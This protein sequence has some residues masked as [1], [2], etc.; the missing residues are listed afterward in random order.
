MNYANLSATPSRG[1]PRVRTWFAAGKTLPAA[2]R[3]KEWA[4]GIEPMSEAVTMQNS[5]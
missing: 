5:R 2:M 1:L 3:H 4:R